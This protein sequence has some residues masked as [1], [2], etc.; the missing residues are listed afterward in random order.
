MSL[1]IPGFAAFKRTNRRWGFNIAAY[2]SPHSLTWRWL[3]HAN[4]CQ[5][6]WWPY[7][8]AN[9]IGFGFGIGFASANAYLSHGGGWNFNVT[10]LGLHL[11]FQ[12]QRPMWYRDLYQRARDETDQLRG[13][14]WVRDDHPH[15]VN[16]PPRPNAMTPAALQ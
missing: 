10:L 9:S 1:V 2:H 16:I 6:L 15:K 8:Q 4:P 13:H 7:V 3:L 5:V 14:L 11:G 12:Q